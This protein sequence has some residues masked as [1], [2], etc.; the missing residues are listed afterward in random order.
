MQMQHCFKQKMLVLFH[1]HHDKE[2]E[3]GQFTHQLASMCVMVVLT[4]PTTQYVCHGGPHQAYYTVCDKLYYCS[5]TQACPDY[6][7]VVLPTDV[8]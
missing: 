3:S 1:K 6:M 8:A 7:T 2:N 4:R 5:T